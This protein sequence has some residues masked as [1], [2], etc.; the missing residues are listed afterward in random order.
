MEHQ[1]RAHEH[2]IP[3]LF[4]MEHFTPDTAGMQSGLRKI[5]ER[6]WMHVEDTEGRI[7]ATEKLLSRS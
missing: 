1:L 4:S 6:E 7:V 3:S 2:I 5:D